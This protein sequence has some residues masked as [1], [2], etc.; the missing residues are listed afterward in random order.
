[1]L[2]LGACFLPAFLALGLVP[3]VISLASG[4]TGLG[5]F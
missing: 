2:P 4:L 3:V 5:V 1:M